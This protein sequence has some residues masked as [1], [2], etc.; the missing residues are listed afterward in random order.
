MQ[1][2]PPT[3]S[4]ATSLQ[5]LSIQRHAAE[6]A[7]ASRL[8]TG[9][10][11]FRAPRDRPFEVAVNENLLVSDADKAV[12][13]KNGLVM[14]REVLGV[15]IESFDRQTHRYRAPWYVFLEPIQRRKGGGWRVYRSAL[16]GTISNDVASLVDRWLDPPESEDDDIQADDVQENAAG[17]ISWNEEQG[18]RLA[19][20]VRDLRLKL[21]QEE[22][23]G[24]NKG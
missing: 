9:A 21:A 5:T 7:A 17:N 2:L 1:T 15:R 16:P 14:G 11:L 12:A 24:G 3:G 22:L 10:T 19:G 4:D 23:L 13:L 6:S 8:V 20:F 18:K